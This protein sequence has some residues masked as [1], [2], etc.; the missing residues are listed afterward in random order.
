MSDLDDLVHFANN[1]SIAQFLTDAFPYPYLR[2]HGIAFL[3]NAVSQHPQQIFAIEVNVRAAGAIGIHP[4]KDIYQ[5][6]AELGYWLAEE[7]W[8]KGLM[9]SALPQVISYAF[10]HFDIDRIFARP[11]SNN[12]GSQKVIMNCGF[13]L[14]ARIERSLIKNDERLDEL[15]FAIR[16]QKYNI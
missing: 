13:A 9:S 5:K 3:E 8:G 15:I 6:N 12:P 14:E 4:Q 10:D 7:Y 16:K 2:E 11:F 1:P